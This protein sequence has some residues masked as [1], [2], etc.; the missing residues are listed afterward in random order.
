M[1][2]PFMARH[3]TTLTDTIPDQLKQC[4]NYLNTTE[5]MAVLRVTRATL[6]GWCRAGAVPYT[7]MPDMSYRFDA[8]TLAAWLKRRSVG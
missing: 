7:R 3:Q 2:S 1:V 6:C 5:A 4:G 8:G